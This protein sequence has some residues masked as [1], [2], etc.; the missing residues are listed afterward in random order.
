[1]PKSR[2]NHPELSRIGAMLDVLEAEDAVNP[3]RERADALGRIHLLIAELRI[4]L[5]SALDVEV[6]P[7]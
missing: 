6:T 3:S 2:M 5:E 7:R 1:M 4:R